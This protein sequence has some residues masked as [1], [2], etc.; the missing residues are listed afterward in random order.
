[1][2]Y[3]QTIEYL[4]EKLPMFSRTGAA[5][6]K[7][8]LTNTILLCRHLGNPQQKFKSVHVGGTNGKGSVS[9]ML[10]SVFQEHGLKTGLYTSP[11]LYDFR[12]RIKVNGAL[13]S[14]AFV[15]DFV[16]KI[17]PLIE[18]V[19]PSFFEITVAM[20]FAF[21]AGQD[22]DVAVIEVGLGGRLD[23]TNIILPE[24]SV[25]TNIG[26]DH[27]NLLGNT[28]EK[29]AAEKGGIIK[30]G[31]PVIIGER[32]EATDHIF[33]ETANQKAAP[34]FFAPDRFTTET[35]TI[36]N[37]RLLVNVLD[38]KTDR[39]TQHNL[40]LAGIYQTKNICTVLQ[41][42]EVLAEQFSLNSE[43]TSIAL[44]RVKQNT[45][46]YGRWEIVAKNPKIVLDVAHNEAGIKELL[47]QLQTEK[48]ERLH[49]VL[50]MVKDKDISAVLALLPPFAQY[51][52]TQ[53][54]IPRALPATLLKDFAGKKNLA[55]GA[56]DNVNLALSAAK[57]K[58]SKDDLI[59]VCGSVFLIA[60][61]DA[62]KL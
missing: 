24:A 10:A 47:K 20:A 18:T 53:A 41:A 37:D 54:A 30:N 16:E 11:H 40:D 19:Q 49:I 59:L 52:F 26:W 57:E 4:F 9:H 56:Y 32:S 58:A 42:V 39:L 6:Y 29:I 7:A 62:T 17:K 3:P 12:E 23:S 35:F 48:F 38:K 33:L 51:Y 50:G 22:V 13:V 46:L 60:E 1:M 5:A 61:V 8:D 31:V 15:I 45:G 44:S 14:E 2:N 36:N 34:I 28:L 25:V 27:M 21:F 55:G 43:K